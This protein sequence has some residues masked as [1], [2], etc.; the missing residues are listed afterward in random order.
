VTSPVGLMMIGAT[1]RGL[2]F[3][4]FGDCQKSLLAALMEEYPRAKI[5]AMPKPYPPR[6]EGP[7]RVAEAAS[8]RRGTARRSPARYPRYGFSNARMALSAI[9][10]LRPSTV[11]HRGRQRHWAP[12]TRA[13][14]GACAAN[15]VALVIPCHRFI[16]GSGDMGGYRWG[17]VRKRTLIDL[18]RRVA[19]SGPKS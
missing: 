1:D 2:T 9:D 11:L 18:E 7:G 5:E 12:A 10:S 17:V 15:R 4:Q 14:A 13:V 19:A 8:R 16:R 3:V 6:F